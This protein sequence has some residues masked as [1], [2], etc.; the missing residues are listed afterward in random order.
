[1]KRS[2]QSGFTLV[3]LIVTMTI[4]AIVSVGIFGFIGKQHQWVCGIKKP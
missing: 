4:L 3:E 1:M 2:Y